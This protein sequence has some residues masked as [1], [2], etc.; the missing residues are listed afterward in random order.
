M[1]HFSIVTKNCTNMI[2]HLG[3]ISTTSLSEEE[4]TREKSKV[5]ILFNA[6]MSV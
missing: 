1:E 3:T 6:S 5:I 2:R 4:E